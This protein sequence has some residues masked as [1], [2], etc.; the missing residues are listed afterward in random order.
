MSTKDR[1]E[2]KES[3]QLRRLGYE[4][5]PPVDEYS[6][7]PDSGSRIGGVRGK[8]EY[9]IEGGIAW[10]DD[11]H[12]KVTANADRR[13]L[14]DPT[15][16]ASDFSIAAT[17]GMEGL[18]EAA[19]E[20]HPQEIPP[21]YLES[22]IRERLEHHHKIHAQSLKVDVTPTGEV[23]VSGEVPSESE[24]LRINEVL[25]ALPGVRTVTCL[26]R[27]EKRGVVEGIPSGLKEAKIQPP[28]A[29]TTTPR[30]PPTPHGQE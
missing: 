22:L 17:H 18:Y 14:D 10:E 25:A 15:T 9:G 20:E 21:P 4:Y 5:K 28:S 19:R 24:R 29:I 1:R 8:N 30:V 2:G 7:Q 27:V 3:N 13:P 23:T 6:Y 26:I 12:G 11:A 16:G